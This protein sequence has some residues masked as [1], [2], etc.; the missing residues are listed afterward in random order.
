[1]SQSSQFDQSTLADVQTV[2]NLT[3][4]AAMVVVT[5]LSRSWP[6]NL[7][8]ARLSKVRRTSPEIVARVRR[9]L[10]HPLD[11]SAWTVKA[12]FPFPLISVIRASCFRDVTI[13]RE[14]AHRGGHTMRS[15][16]FHINLSTPN[17]EFPDVP[18]Q[19]PGWT[20]GFTMID[21]D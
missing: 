5:I 19:I 6:G 21:S 18:L 8:W 7:S 10:L 2:Q 3:M 1:M 9:P 17:F 11:V 4:F 13:E 15:S 12:F 16:S 14:P 20:W